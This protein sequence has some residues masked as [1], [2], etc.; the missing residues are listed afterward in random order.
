MHGLRSF[1]CLRPPELA[2]N[3]RLTREKCVADGTRFLL[4]GR[5]KGR[6]RLAL[7]PAPFSSRFLDAA[8]EG[9][10]LFRSSL[11][12]TQDSRGKEAARRP[13]ERARPTG[14]GVSR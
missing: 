12:L 6:H 1:A 4:R 3:V 11:A 14:R 2:C 5:A 7:R 13:Q 10:S 9:N 8:R